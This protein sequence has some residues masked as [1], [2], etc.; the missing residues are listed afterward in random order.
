MVLYS[1]KSLI[2]R[3]FGQNHSRNG[4]WKPRVRYCVYIYIYTFWGSVPWRSVSLPPNTRSPR[5]LGQPFRSGPARR[6]TV[7]SDRARYIKPITA[8]AGKMSWALM[9]NPQCL[10]SDAGNAISSVSSLWRERID[11][12][13]D[14]NCTCTA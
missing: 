9:M 2:M 12:G 10:E 6:E 13:I 14:C 5:P 7:G 1:V 11:N 4:A 8:L 3:W